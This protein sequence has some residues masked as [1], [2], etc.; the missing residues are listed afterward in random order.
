MKIRDRYLTGILLVLIGVIIGTLFALYQLPMQV[1]DKADV[2][3][4]EVKHSSKPIFTDEQLQKLDS[5]F[6][7]RKIADD[8]TPTV[9]KIETVVPFSS[10]DMPDDEYHDRDGFWGDI[11]P[12]RARTVGSGIFITSDGY[13]LTNNHVIDGAVDDQIEVE[14]RDK[15]TF[16]AR[17]VG[18]DPSTD[19]AVIKIDAKDLPAITIGN[20]DK[21]NVGEWVL[22]IGNPFRLNSTVTAG[23]VSALSREVQII[24]DQMRIESFIQTDAA[25]NKGNSGGPLVNTS[26]ELIGVNTAIASQS[27]S[28]QGYGFAVPS[29]LAAK[30]AKDII[31]F[32]EVHRALLGVAISSIN[33]VRAKSLNMDEIRGVQVTDVNPGGAADESGLKRN[34]VIL[35]VNGE[36]VN[37][38]N[39]LQQKIAILRPGETV[40]LRILR[41]GRELTKNV[42]LDMLEREQLAVSESSTQQ[43]YKPEDSGSSEE[44]PGREGVEFATFGQG[45]RVMALL[46]AGKTTGYDLIIT[47]VV[48]G[49]QASRIGF[50]EGF[51]IREVE[52]QKVED[53]KSLKDLIKQSSE[54][55]N[56]IAFKVETQ[57]GKTRTFELKP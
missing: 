27:G 39:Q 24:N 48:E 26:G 29:N 51:I 36:E 6:L 16:Q 56:K 43:Y 5:R 37:Q 38:S 53:L 52:G 3:V 20:S 28:Y 10:D 35:S 44:K 18:Q 49:S 55:K 15:R 13:I 7:F 9:V 33:D 17:I 50:K 47:D 54:D 30:V 12:K 21:V 32:G 34:D 31:E 23:I 11:L 42:E 40:E 46:H 2:T 1:D 19:L 4:T 41:D 14:L 45:F 57:E 25:I 8:V 22:A